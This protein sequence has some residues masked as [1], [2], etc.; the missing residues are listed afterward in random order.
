M[1]DQAYTVEPRTWE[2]FGAANPDLLNTQ[3]LKA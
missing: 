3:V 2:A 1:K